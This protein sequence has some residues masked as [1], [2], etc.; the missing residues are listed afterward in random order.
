MTKR[1]ARRQF[2]HTWT[3]MVYL[4]HAAVSP[5]GF[6]VRDAVD[7]YQTRRSL[8]GIDPFPYALR[9]AHETRAL[10]AELIHARPEQIGFVMNTSD[11]LNILAQGLTWQLGDRIVL[12]ELEFPA[13]AYPFV[14]LQRH[15]V[16][17]DWV[18]A[19]EHR[20]TPKS[21]AEALTDRTRLVSISHVQFSTGARAD[22]AAIGQL[23]HERGIPLAVD[24]IQSL[25]HTP[26]DVERMHVDFL[27][28]GSHKWL[29][30]AEGAGFVF[31]SDRAISL[32]HQ[33]SLG[34]TSVEDAFDF[35]LHPE[36]LRAG[37][38]RFEGGTINFS[39]IAALK[40][41]LE[42]F[43]EY[44][45]EAMTRDVLELSGIV[46]DGLSQKGFEIVTPRA[47][48]ER[49]GIVSFVVPEPQ[50]LFDRL[51]RANIHVSL[52]A[53]RLRVAPHFYNT[54]EEVRRLL[55]EL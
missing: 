35:S 48:E 33:A 13:N 23:C 49:S 47:P 21:I 29:M 44:G 50:E 7:R 38:A 1:E 27:A 6:R 18:R 53:G 17:I 19:T 55:A 45:Y 39:A 40:A 28:C 5:L 8:D 14:N 46:L 54:E 11:G 16:E 3:D 4:N 41:S 34:W 10:L 15:G 2:P 43:R 30:A 26:I 52:R 31:A 25:P 20:I 12:N 51:M 36:R 42:F 24:A 9:M 22:L 32:I 37:A